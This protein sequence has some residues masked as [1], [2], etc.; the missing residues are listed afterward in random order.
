MT[1][2][3]DGSTQLVRLYV[4]V[5]IHQKMLKMVEVE[6]RKTR[7]SPTVNTIIVSV[8]LRDYVDAYNVQARYILHAK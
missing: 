4:Q 2:P 6:S 5:N 3:I 1:L 7:T 8:Q